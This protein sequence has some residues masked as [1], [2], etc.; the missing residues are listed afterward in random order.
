MLARYRQTDKERERDRN[1]NRNRKQTGTLKESVSHIQPWKLES[2]RPFVRDLRSE[3]SE[4]GLILGLRGL[5]L[6]LRGLFEA[7]QANF[8]QGAEL[9]PERLLRTDLM[10]GRTNLRLR[11]LI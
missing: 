11:W 6:G 2:V 7:E 1:R 5:I 4:G 9:G 3:G 10:H 8:R